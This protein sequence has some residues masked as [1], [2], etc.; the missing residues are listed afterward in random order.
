MLTSFQFAWNSVQTLVPLIVGFVGLLVTVA[1]ETFW[2]KEP[3]LRHGLYHNSS[4]IAAY[5]GGCIQGLVVRESVFP[6]I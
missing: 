1:Y 3:F 2:A 5:L 6:Y 4:S